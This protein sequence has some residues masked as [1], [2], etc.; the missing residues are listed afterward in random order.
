MNKPQ[1]LKAK[2]IG[3]D[4]YRENI[5]FM[6]ADCQV[7][8][9]EG[10]T[11]LKRIVVHFNS[12]SIIAT[13]NVVH[14]D[15]LSS[16]EA[17]LSMEAMKRLGVNDGELISVSHLKHISSLSLVRAKLYDKELSEQEFAEI[18]SDIAAGMYSNIELAAF[19]SACAGDNLSKNEIIGLTKAMIN[20]GQRIQWNNKII[21]DK[22]CV[23]GLPGNRTTPIIVSIVA[24]AG[25]TIPK[26]SSRAITSPAGTADT[27]ETMS[28][29][30]LS[31]AEIK[32]VV[33]QENGCIVWGGAVQLSPADDIL[34]SVEKA[35]EVDS[36]GQMIASVLSK[37][38]AAGATHVLIDIPVGDT[39]KVRSAEEA[40]LLQSYFEAVGNAI[41]L[42]VKV[43][44]TD[45]S[46]PVGRGIGP[47]LE[48]LDVLSVLRNQ[49]FAPMDLKET[50]IW[51]AGELLELSGQFAV[52]T[53]K[54]QAET[55]LKSG[56]ALSKFI[57]ICHKQGGFKEPAYA[58][59]KQDVLS[60]KGGIVKAV[61]NRKLARIAKLA[62]APRSA[63]AGILFHSPLGKK[64][65]KGDVLFTVYAEA[66]G[67]LNYALEY[68]KD[69]N[70]IITI[71]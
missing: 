28:P 42:K 30:N 60:E 18:I 22:H 56:K 54:K 35:L 36:G 25:L 14:S 15:L 41:G 55:I 44:L 23:G 12:K 45:G 34:I 6:R 2:N 13:L 46:Q 50:A 20:T 47:S 63:S 10:F 66:T 48:A 40:L 4:T 39:A 69:N 62:G 19:I 7:C 21:L 70:N 32:Q 58:R 31:L 3:I 59:F 61:D 67:E 8:L 33:G 68:M 26:T 24:A 51:L 1:Q 43:V 71:Q 11:A 9:S 64:V 27:M 57:S 65:N 49:E 16:G 29:V 37:K 53:G 52:G 17:G 5:I 38:V